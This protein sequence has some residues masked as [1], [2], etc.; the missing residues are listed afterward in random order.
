VVLIADGVS[1]K[2]VENGGAGTQAILKEAAGCDRVVPESHRVPQGRSR[3][4]NHQTLGITTFSIYLEIQNDSPTQ[5]A[6]S[7][8]M[9]PP[10]HHLYLDY[11]VI[12]LARK[13]LYKEEA[14]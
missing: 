7:G 6:F 11:R 1:N 14:Q 10:S 9:S 12:F 3:T 2:K 4:P 13:Y 8:L 5:G